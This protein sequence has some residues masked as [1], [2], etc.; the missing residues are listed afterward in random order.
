MTILEA[1]QEANDTAKI[2]TLAFANIQEFQSFMDSFTFNDYPVNIVIPPSITGTR[3]SNRNKIVFAIQGWVLQRIPEDTNDYRSIK[4]Q[5]T[6]MAPMQTLA[7]KFINALLKTGED[8]GEDFVDPE[9]EEVSWTIR[10]EYAFL[11]DHLFGCS[12]TVN[13]PST[14]TICTV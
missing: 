2:R 5:E 6:Y 10:P 14:T 12:Y 8:D 4:I 3:T 11:P 9:V 13:L 7:T 1:I